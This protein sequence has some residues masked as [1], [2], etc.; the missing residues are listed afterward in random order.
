M[1]RTSLLHLI[2]DR[3]NITDME[4]QPPKARRRGRPP[5]HAEGGRETRELLLRAGLEALTE[6]GFAA[7]GIDEVLRRVGVPKGS[8]YHYFESKEAFGSE[9][10]ERYGA[11]FARKLERHFTDES[12]TP[13]ERLRAFIAEAQAGMAKHKYQRGC[14]IGNLGQ[15]MGALPES[16]RARLNEVFADWQAHV[17]RCLTEAQTAGEI[18]ELANCNQ[19]AAFFWI[20]WEGAVLRSKLER[21]PEALRI[22]ADGFFTGLSHR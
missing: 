10:I 11:Y 18:S 3:S 4:T 22:F 12:H 7:T 9:L 6:K 16:F 17:E 8:F 13:L 20:G 14:L 1:Q 21:N 2:D 5:K 19:L 15:E